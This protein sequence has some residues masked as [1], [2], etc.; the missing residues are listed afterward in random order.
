MEPMSP[1]EREMLERIFTDAGGG[2]EPSWPSLSPE[3]R[4]AKWV[5]WDNELE[6]LSL[7]RAIGE[8]VGGASTCWSNLAGAGEFLSEEAGIIADALE[9]KIRRELTR[10]VAKV[11]DR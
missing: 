10:L 5:L 4:R 7:H 6:P 2:A 1:V 11:F 9:R 3:E 8:A